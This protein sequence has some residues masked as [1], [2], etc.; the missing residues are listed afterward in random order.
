MD[1]AGPGQPCEML[2]D[3]AMARNFP[4]GRNLAERIECEQAF[5]QRSMGN[6]KRGA[7]PASA[8][9]EQYVEIE[10]ACAPALPAS[11][12]EAPFDC[13]QVPQKFGWS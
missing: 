1:G 9:P 4:I 12:P 8:R 3:G 10:H 6:G 2:S 13:F 5:G 7:Q 11:P